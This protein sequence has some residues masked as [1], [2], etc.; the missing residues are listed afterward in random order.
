M[1]R[2]FLK[3]AFVALCAGSLISCDEDTV[4][5]G[6]DNFVSF[7]DVSSTRIQFF[8]NGGISETAVNLAFPKSTDVVVNF[9]VKSD[10]AIEGTDYV[11][12]TPGVITIPAGS[13][14]ANIRIE[15][16]D[17]DVQDDSKPLNIALTGTNDATVTLGLIDNG[18]KN[19][20]LL[21]VNN[22]CTTNFQEFIGQLGATSSGNTIGS[23]VATANDNGDCNILLI[24]GNLAYND[25]IKLASDKA[26]VF[27]LKPGA[28]ANS[29]TITAFEQAY[30]IDCVDFGDGPIDIL[31][32]AKGNY[33][34]INNP[35]NK[36]K[37]LIINATL[38]LEDGRNPGPSTVTLEVPIN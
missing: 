19:K 7:D 13:T 8:E 11:L 3:L 31:F 32:E 30:C 25:N 20:R 27:E 18:S 14:S 23:A 17:N 21:I 28:S 33:Q 34:I 9:T 2:Y 10:V 12:L 15:V 22:D 4:T 24:K 29:G 26:L 38:T 5:Y 6:G 16:K 37:R 1:K 36:A 35:N